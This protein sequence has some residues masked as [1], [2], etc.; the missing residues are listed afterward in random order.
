[1]LLKNAYNKKKAN[2][3]FMYFHSIII[4]GHDNNSNLKTAYNYIFQY[5]QIPETKKRYI[6]ENT[7]KDFL[8]VQKEQNSISIELIRS[9]LEFTNLSPVLGNKKAILIHEAELMLVNAANSILKVLEEPPENVLLI[10]TTTHLFSILPTI[11]SR[12]IKVPVISDSQLNKQ[13]LEIK[14][15]LTATNE[16]TFVQIQNN[17]NMLIVDVIISI[18]KNLYVQLLSDFSLKTALKITKLQTLYRLSKNTY[19]N[20]EYLLSIVK[21][22]YNA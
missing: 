12:C 9:I 15:L 16:N 17:L 10:L 11:R 21:Y 2:I 5:L 8:L 3:F 13:D 6:Y 4:F 19:P 1:M 7:Y 22:I 14:S 18:M 20:Q